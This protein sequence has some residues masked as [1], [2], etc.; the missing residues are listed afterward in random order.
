[1]RTLP[2]HLTVVC[3]PPHSFHSDEL[4]LAHTDARAADRLQNQIQTVVFLLLRGVQQP[5]VF[6]FGQ[7]FFLAAKY[8]LLTFDLFHAAVMPAEKGKQAVD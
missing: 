1:M 5:N 7:F 2:L 8:L 6:G 4:Q 3:L